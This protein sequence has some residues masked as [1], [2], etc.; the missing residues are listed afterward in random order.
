MLPKVCSRSH[1]QPRSGS[2][3]LAISPSSAPSA[4]SASLMRPHPCRIGGR[5]LHAQTVQGHEHAGGGAPDIALAVGDVAELDL[6]ARECGA[7]AVAGVTGGIE[8]MIYP[9]PESVL[10]PLPGPRHREDR[11]HQ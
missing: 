1:G 9:H 5:R 11:L 10:N 3:S 8:E 7:A 4:V 2:R 6:L